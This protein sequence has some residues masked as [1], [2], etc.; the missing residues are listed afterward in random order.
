MQ[1]LKPQIK[2]WFFPP[3]MLG[4]Y[5]AIHISWDWIKSLGL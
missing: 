3:I 4:D 2:V 1:V 5:L